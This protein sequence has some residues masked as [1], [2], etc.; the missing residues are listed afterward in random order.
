MNIKFFVILII[1]IFGLG[2]IMVANNLQG[3]DL[4]DEKE[5]RMYSTGECKSGKDP[6]KNIITARAKGK[7]GVDFMN[8]GYEVG[9]FARGSGTICVSCGGDA[10]SYKVEVSCRAYKPWNW[11]WYEVPDVK[12]DYSPEEKKKT[13]DAPADVVAK[14]KGT[15]TKGGDKT[16]YE[17]SG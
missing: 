3:L 12:V 1:I 16:K 8:A 17:C 14:V 10:K 7:L 9:D 5:G 13:C 15:A 4:A 11:W 2:A 6:E